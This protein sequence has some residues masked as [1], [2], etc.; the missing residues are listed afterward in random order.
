M[1][2]VSMRTVVM[3]EF[4]KLSDIFIKGAVDRRPRMLSDD[5][6]DYML[7]V[8]ASVTIDDYSYIRTEFS[9]YF[10]D[11]YGNAGLENCAIEGGTFA[12]DFTK[13][14]IS[15]VNKDNKSLGRSNKPIPRF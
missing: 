3:Q 5:Y 4:D 1:A 6:G 8:D 14:S 7:G 15:S 11:S 12:R 10:G 2:N 13:E 9:S